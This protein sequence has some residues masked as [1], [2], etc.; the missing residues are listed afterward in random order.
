MIFLK[1]YAMI[2]IGKKEEIFI[3]HRKKT[4]TKDIG[5]VVISATKET[6]LPIGEE[7]KEVR[8]LRTKD[9]VQLVLMSAI[10]MPTGK[11]IDTSNNETNETWEPNEAKA[12]SCIAMRER[13]FLAPIPQSTQQTLF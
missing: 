5:P 11:I 6:Q 13:N 9:K 1:I 8:I 7:V 12:I 4:P 2:L 10:I 3:F